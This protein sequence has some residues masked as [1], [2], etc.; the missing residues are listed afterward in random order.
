MATTS[1]AA[2][3]LGSASLLQKVMSLCKRRSFIH[4]SSELYGG[5]KGCYDYG[6]LGTELK[7]NIAHEWYVCCKMALSCINNQYI[8]CRS[9]FILCFAYICLSL[10]F[11][12][13]RYI[14][15]SIH[16]HCILFL[17]GGIFYFTWQY[18][19][20]LFAVR[21]VSLC[22]LSILSLYLLKKSY[23]VL[24]DTIKYG[25]VKV[26]VH[27]HAPRRRIRYRHGNPYAF[28][29]VAI[30]GAFDRVCGFARGLS[31]IGG[32]VPCRC[33]H[34]YGGVDLVF[35][36]REISALLN[37]YNTRIGSKKC[38]DIDMEWNMHFR[39]KGLY[40]VE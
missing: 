15:Y 18:W 26:A 21:T 25:F 23:I 24:F 6:P 13:S 35:K 19:L 11:I 3:G 2:A 29:G 1:S 33:V 22:L 17:F 27:R 8:K 20:S 36:A 32:K 30:V 7:R 28:S 5:L 9:M 40:G 39:V 38:V 4:Q 12:C 10:R 14:K 37:T 16:S 31:L 34:V